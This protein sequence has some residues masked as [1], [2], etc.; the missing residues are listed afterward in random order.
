ML[1]QVYQVHA[2][3]FEPFVQYYVEN[4]AQFIFENDVLLD[5]QKRAVREL[6]LSL[7]REEVA[8]FVLRDLFAGAAHHHRPVADGLE[9]F[10]DA[11]GYEPRNL[12]AGVFFYE[13]EAHDE[14]AAQQRSRQVRALVQLQHGHD[15]VFSELI[16]FRLPDREAL[17]LQPVDDFADVHVRRGQDQ[18]EAAGSYLLE[19]LFCEVV[20]VLD[21]L[22]Q[23]G[24]DGKFCPQIKVGGVHFLVYYA[25]EKHALVF[26]VEHLYAAVLRVVKQLV[27]SDHLGH[28]VV[29][30]HDECE[31]II[32]SCHYF[33]LF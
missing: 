11:V 17:F 28:H 18:R 29:V 31:A 14:V 1:V 13:L 24:V 32:A 3:N 12:R 10:V 6:R 27:V 21:Y 30:L 22:V 4:F 8:D 9:I 19:L 26:H 33:Y 25:L 20:A 2:R 23:T 16:H 7:E 5:D 15:V